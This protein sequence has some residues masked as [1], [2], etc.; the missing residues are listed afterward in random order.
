MSLSHYRRDVV[1]QELIA[2]SLTVNCTSIMWCPF[3]LWI[4]F[5]DLLISRLI[6]TRFWQTLSLFS[7]F[8]RSFT[9]L[10]IISP[11]TAARS[12]RIWSQRR[13]MWKRLWWWTNTDLIT[14]WCG[15]G[16]CLT[17]HCGSYCFCSSLS[18]L[19]NITTT[20]M[21]LTYSCFVCE[22]FRLCL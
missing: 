20:F 1:V 12:K 16:T 13:S 5:S 6:L 9:T 21:L 8:F 22:M 11:T 15:W 2:W 4:T 18:W 7:F 17:N 14:F 10:L 3:F 19:C